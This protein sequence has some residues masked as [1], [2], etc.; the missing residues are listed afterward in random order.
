MATDYTVGIQRQT[1]VNQPGVGLVQVMSIPVT[2]T[3]GHTFTLNV[4]LATYSNIAAVKKLIQ[5]R[6]NQIN[7]VSSL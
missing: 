4:D 5:D 1:T 7:A 2:T 3:T 6:V